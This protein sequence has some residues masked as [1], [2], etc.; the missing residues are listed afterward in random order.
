MTAPIRA[1]REIYGPAL[2]H[3]HAVA[4]QNTFRT[5]W[6]WLA[7]QILAAAKT[8]YLFDIGC[9]QGAWLSFAHNMKI[10]GQGIDISEHFI[11]MARDAGVHANLESAQNAA[12]PP[13][14]TAVTALGEV[15]A[16]KPA[17]LA[18]T[19]LNLARK[20]PPG[21]L[22]FCDLPGPDTPEG[23][24]DQG[25]DGWRMSVQIRKKGKTLY[26]RIQIETAEAIEQELHEQTL[27]APREALE[28][29]EG[30][31]LKAEILDSYGPCALL[32]GRYALRAVKP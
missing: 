8:P 6:P 21:G 29:A 11:S 10:I 19:I 12:T 3:I 9:G 20:L 17:A 13:G 16:Y 27:F 15:L 32:P 22:L 14:L 28:I 26:R 1:R 4:F 18:P 7:E 2:A 24:R 5:A 30:F 31:G 25:G 23:D